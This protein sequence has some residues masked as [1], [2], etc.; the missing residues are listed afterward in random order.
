MFPFSFE[1]PLTIPA[2]PY[3]SI[4][5][6][7][8]AAWIFDFCVMNVSLFIFLILLIGI[9]GLFARE[10]FWGMTIIFL[11]FS[12]WRFE[13]LTCDDAFDDELL[14]DLRR[15]EVLAS[16]ALNDEILG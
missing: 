2:N 6:F 1:A 12:C 9:F 13:L 11:S 10:T 3:F 16:P 5:N 4:S 8:L 15:D 7:L 14:T